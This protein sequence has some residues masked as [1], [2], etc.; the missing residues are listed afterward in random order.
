MRDIKT[1]EADISKLQAELE[2]AKAYDSMRTSAVHILKNLGWTWTRKH[3]WKR[4]AT[5][6]GS[7]F[8][9]STMTHIKAGDY[10]HVKTSLSTGP[11]QGYAYVWSVKGAYVKI[12]FVNAVYEGQANVEFKQCTVMAKECRVVSKKEVLD[13]YNW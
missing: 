4:P 5:I 10:V 6:K 7:V 1:I 8:N 12:S 13:D 9:A 3:G 11:R 2:D